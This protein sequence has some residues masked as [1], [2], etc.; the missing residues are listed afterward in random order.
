MQ[1]TGHQGV[2]SRRD[3]KEGGSVETKH[4]I[5]IRRTDTNPFNK[6]IGKVFDIA[7]CYRY[8]MRIGIGKD[9]DGQLN[10]FGALGCRNSVQKLASG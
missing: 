4:F 5:V 9:I 6:A 2:L 3:G 7:M 8:P 10:S 1:H